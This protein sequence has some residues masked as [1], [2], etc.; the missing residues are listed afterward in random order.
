MQNILKKF[1]LFIVLSMVM[2]L[3][4]TLHAQNSEEITF[5]TYYPSPYGSYGQ[6]D[7]NYVTITNTPNDPGMIN[8]VPGSTPAAGL[9]SEGSLYYDKNLHKFMY[10][11]NTGSWGPLGGGAYIIGANDPGYLGN[12]GNQACAAVGRTC[13]RVIS[14]NYIAV[15]AGCPSATHCLRVCMTWYNQPLPGVTLLMGDADNIHSCDALLGNHTTYLDSGI[16]ECKA[17]FSAVCN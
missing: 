6:L 16:V 10:K 1:S 7:A 4:I 12:T 5:T 15:D 14:Y 8:F 17:F 11:N 13:N 3:T 2:L 9:G